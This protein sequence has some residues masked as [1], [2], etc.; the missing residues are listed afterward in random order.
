M[1]RAS[2]RRRVMAPSCA[3]RPAGRLGAP[4]GVTQRQRELEPGLRVIEGVAEALAQP[5]KA[6]AHRLG[7]QLKCPGHGQRPAGMIESGGERLAQQLHAHRRG[8]VE[9]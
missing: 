3:K 9:P 7:M 8:V 6:I 1:Q 5:P 4:A 2:A